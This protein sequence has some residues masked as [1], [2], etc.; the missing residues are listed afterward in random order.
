MPTSPERVNGYID[1]FSV[2]YGFRSKG[3]QR[4]LWL[5][6]RALISRLI[7]SPQALGEVK[8]FTSRIKKPED[9]RAR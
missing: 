7:R 5:D 4:Y 2:Y 8:Y 1:G 3:W 9:S 6:Y